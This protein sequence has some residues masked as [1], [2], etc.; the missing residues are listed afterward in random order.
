MK[1]DDHDYC[2]NLFFRFQCLQ[3]FKIKFDQ[4]C[5]HPPFRQETRTAMTEHLNQPK[6]R[7][8]PVQHVP[9]I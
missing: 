3:C 8:R 4:N 5:D 7:G 6:Y 2:Q 1:G 9:D